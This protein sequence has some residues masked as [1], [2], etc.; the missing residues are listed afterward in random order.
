MTH[1]VLN[2]G[3]RTD[4]V[5]YSCRDYRTISNTVAR[6]L[7]KMEGVTWTLRSRESYDEAVSD[8]WIPIFESFIP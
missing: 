4:F 3:T 7:W 5:A 8:G 1:Q 6:K 2:C